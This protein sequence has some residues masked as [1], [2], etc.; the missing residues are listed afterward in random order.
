[1]TSHFFLTAMVLGILLNSA[2]NNANAEEKKPLKDEAYWIVPT[3]IQ[4]SPLMVPVAG[5]RTAPV[6]IY[7]EAAN[8]KYVGNICNNVP[9]IR[10]AIYQELSRNPVPVVQQKLVLKDIPHR[11]KGPM[12]AAIGGRQIK[13]VFVVSGAVK[14]EGGGISRLPFA[15]INGCQSIRQAEAARM[16]A[17]AK[18][19]AQ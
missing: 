15:R 3:H 10:D 4:L 17:K 14:M 11:I 7:L 2:G 12:N 19:K 16:K 8:K 18:E 9:R 5:R 6:T 13:E 1:M